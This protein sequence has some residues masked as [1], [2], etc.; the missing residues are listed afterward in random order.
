[1]ILSQNPHQIYFVKICGRLCA[2]DA[3]SITNSIANVHQ[4]ESNQI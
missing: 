1:M 3:E 2:T 4:F